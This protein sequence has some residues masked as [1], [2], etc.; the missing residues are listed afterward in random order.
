M[1]WSLGS[2]LL[3]ILLAALLVPEQSVCPYPWIGCQGAPTVTFQQ[4]D[5]YR[6]VLLGCDRHDLA[7]L[8]HTLCAHVLASPGAGS[9]A[10]V[11]A[12]CRALSSLNTD[13]K[14]Q[15]WSNACRVIQ[16]LLAPLLGGAHCALEP[17]PPGP[18]DAAPAP[19]RVA[20]EA[21][22]LQQLACDYDGWLAGGA[23][24]VLVSLCSDN[25]RE[26]FVGR[27]CGGAALMR[28]LL[29]D[30]TNSWL[31]GFCA[32]SSADA[33]NL[34]AQLCV[35]EQWVLQPSEAVDPA[36]LEFCLKQDGP[37]LSGLICQNTGFFLILFS[38]PENGRLMPNCS[39]LS[40]P[41]PDQGSLTLDSCRYSEWRDLSK[42][43]F[44]LLSQ[45]V[46]FDSLG[47][48]QEV[49]ANATFLANLL[50]SSA[51]AWL[52]DH[53]S[54][55]LSMLKPELTGPFNFADWCDYS[56]WGERDVDDSV[57]GL[58]W[59]SDRAAFV[60]NVCCKVNVFKRLLQD[61]RNE[62]LK[63]VCSNM[64]E[65]ALLAQVSSSLDTETQTLRQR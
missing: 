35:Y 56:T 23:D 48:A 62:W 29:S 32:D 34:V 43:S 60:D 36:L 11:L 13:Q 31:Y 58:C 41:A 57:V 4:A 20:R 21:S 30:G 51:N 19:R 44:D 42:I 25:E 65:V 1:S 37:R 7:E 50:L 61:P 17:G 26:V 24:P 55:S 22:N 33:A 2:S 63:S 64:S 14:E 18:S 3:D 52:E 47:F 59:Q 40:L 49:C 5:D 27:V 9:S 12:L 16:A 28:T 38:N 15:L 54:A 39:A 10:A 53:C 6:N 46:R 8:N 45:C